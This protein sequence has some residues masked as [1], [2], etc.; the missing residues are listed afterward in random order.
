MYVTIWVEMSVSSQIRVYST[1]YTLGA[2]NTLNQ[3]QWRR[4]ATPSMETDR[5]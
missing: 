3:K 1:L 2:G 4:Y 5:L